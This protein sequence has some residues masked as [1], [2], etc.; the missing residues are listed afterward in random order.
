MS[1]DSNVRVQMLKK[2]LKSLN[3]SLQNCIKINKLFC[4]ENLLN[5]LCMF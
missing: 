2:N 4:R 5:K 3:C 1:R